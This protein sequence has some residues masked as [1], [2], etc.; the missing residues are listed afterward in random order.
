MPTIKRPVSESV[1]T[2]PQMDLLARK[3]RAVPISPRNSPPERARTN[4]CSDGNSG[5][6]VS[7]ATPC[8]SVLPQAP[9]A[10][11]SRP[12]DAVVPK[13]INLSPAVLP[14]TNNIAVASSDQR[15]QPN[16]VGQLP[17]LPSLPALPTLPNG[18]TFRALSATLPPGTGSSNL[19]MSK[20]TEPSHATI[21]TQNHVLSMIGQYDSSDEV[22]VH[23][24][25]VALEA[26]NPVTTE[27]E[28]LVTETN[29]PEKGQIASGELPES[30][31][32]S[33]DP[34]LKGIKLQEGPCTRQSYAK[35]TVC[36]LCE[37][38][39]RQQS[40]SDVCAFKNR[41]AWPMAIQGQ[42]KVIHWSRPFFPSSTSEPETLSFPCEFN[43]PLTKDLAKDIKTAIATALEPTLAREQAH[44]ALNNCIRLTTELDARTM[45]DTCSTTVFNG[46]WFCKTCGRELC[47]ACGDELQDKIRNALQDGSSSSSVQ[48]RRL[49]QCSAHTQHG[50]ADLAAE[51]SG[52]LPVT[53]LS[54][55]ELTTILDD[56]RKWLVKHQVKPLQ[57]I[58]D[59]LVQSLYTP[60]QGSSHAYLSVPAG[61]FD[62]ERLAPVQQRAT[63][64][65]Q[66]FQKFLQ[67]IEEKLARQGQELDDVKSRPP[68]QTRETLSRLH[69][70]DER[71]L[72]RQLWSRGETIV[73]ELDL[74]RICSSD[75]TPT[76]FA[77]RF[78]SSPCTL[79][80]NFGRPDK[81]STVAEFFET[82]GHK[83]EL[84]DSRRI[85]DWPSTSDF[86]DPSDPRLYYDD[87][88]DAVNVMF[89]A[90]PDDHGKPGTA[91]WDIFRA[92]DSA[93]IREFLYEKIAAK[94]GKPVEEVMATEDDPIHA[95]QFFLNSALREELLKA[96]GV[97]SW[98][99]MQR[100]GQAVFI[101]AGCAHQ[102]CNLADCIKVASDFVSIENVARCWKVTDEFR[103]QTKGPDL[104]R[105]D[106]L[107]LKTQ[108]FW[109]WLSCQRLTWTEND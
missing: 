47:L 82:F 20:L 38:K 4:G 65:P 76:W 14:T 35:Q 71:K 13:L 66:R 52:F 51:D 50:S 92:Q 18:T 31:Q 70:V 21:Q 10:S 95:Q 68:S 107:Q 41:R 49:R 11:K 101:P 15:E 88:A 46:S 58:D 72:F 1:V 93:K 109:A 69:A 84:K 67:P 34:V 45:C 29:S 7:D 106:V 75:W 54:V 28:D 105:D 33:L 60:G 100:P 108:L 3:R 53:R 61:V 57:V 16:E 2:E 30:S 63:I 56:M 91:A 27:R 40:R 39:P 25:G 55:Q 99:I 86:A 73:V 83:R 64:V 90:S 103:E 78:K 87:L 23:E 6:N 62:R 19:H 94:K 8:I 80:S 36:H 81:P 12:V 43:E 85:K 44:S 5:V 89:W 17:V 102:V 32:P 104:W 26:E 77:E 74:L 9:G 79:S 48:A 96:K 98:R 42:R 59:A 97:K 37:S 24:E 22:D